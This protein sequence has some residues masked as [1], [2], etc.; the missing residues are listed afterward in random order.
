MNS[1][2]LSDSELRRFSDQIAINSIGIEGQLRLKKC[3]IAVVGAGGLGSVVLQLLSSVGIGYL[4]IIDYGM[5]EDKTMQRQTLFGGNDLGKL[6]SILSKEKLQTIF[7]GVYYEIINLEIT[8]ENAERI[9]SKFDIVVDASNVRAT[10][11]IIFEAC[12]KLAI[13]AFFGLVASTTG[14]VTVIDFKNTSK[15]L[16]F[17][18]IFE[19]ENDTLAI[20]KISITY[21]F[22]ATIICN[23]IVNY[24][25]SNYS[26]L[27]SKIISFD[28]AQYNI[29]IR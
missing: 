13:P 29:T 21:N 14:K 20:G 5:V 17:N 8:D 24:I 11:V 28:L 23:E 27:P 22:T 7:P 9:F 2:I 4:G 19:N 15:P 18:D 3:R 16:V 10:S 25:T 12:S 1:N 6:K 26:G